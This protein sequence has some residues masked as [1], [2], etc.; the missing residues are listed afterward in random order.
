MNAEEK[1]WEALWT[2]RLPGSVRIKDIAGHEGI[3][4]VDVPLDHPSV[5]GMV[6]SKDHNT[7]ALAA[8]RVCSSASKAIHQLYPMLLTTP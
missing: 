3:A 6:D 8:L 2:G 5:V 7:R 4:T 1:Y